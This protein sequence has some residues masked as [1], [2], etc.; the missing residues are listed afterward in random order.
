M[1]ISYI[2]PA[3]NCEKTIA[4]TVQSILFYDK[5]DKFEIL[6]IE[7]G[8]TDNTLKVLQLL[9]PAYLLFDHHPPR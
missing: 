7:N 3:Y 9:N 1:N 2:I 6:I 8:S 5:S 4:E